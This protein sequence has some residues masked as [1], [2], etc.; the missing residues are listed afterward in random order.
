MF[1]ISNIVIQAAINSLGT[2]VM[3]AVSVA[4]NIELISYNVLNSFS[5]ACTTFVGQ[6]Y[7]ASDLQRCKKTLKISLLEGSMALAAVIVLILF[8]GESLLAIFNS[9]S[10]VVAIGY[11]RLM[12]IMVSHIVT[13]LYEVLSGY[14]RVTILVNSTADP[15]EME[16]FKR[17]EEE[18]NVKINWLAY[19]GDVATEKKKLMY[20][21]G[22]YADMV[23][24]WLLNDTDIMRYGANEGIYIPLEE[25]IT[26]YAPRIQS[27]LDSFPEGRDTVTTPD[28][29]IYTVPIMVPQPVTENV[30]LINRAWLE[31]VDMEMPATVDELFDVL[32]AFRDEDPNGNGLADEIPFSTQLTGYGRRQE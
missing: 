17:F 18:T 23:G 2:V 5:Q 4:F 32:V 9:D 19:S 20:S 8:F 25:L 1:A 11:I 13:L 28:G 27:C 14:L 15:N 3:A 30:V 10:E 24:G 6:N 31:A 12:I 29:H 16:L 26:Q 22:E 21:S 7:G